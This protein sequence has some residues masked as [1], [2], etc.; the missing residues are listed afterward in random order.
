MIRIGAALNSLLGRRRVPVLLQMTNVECGAACLA[1]ILGYH[2]RKTTVVECREECGVGR[3]GASARVL[4]Q[5]ARRY[6][7]EARAFSTEPSNCRQASLPA[8]AHWG[9][10]HFIVVERWLPHGVVVVDPGL[11]RRTLTEK[12]FDAEFTGVLLTFEPGADF[13]RSKRTTV[14]AW[15][16]YLRGLLNVPGLRGVLAQVLAASLVLQLLGLV[17]PLFTQVLVD[18]VLPF[19]ITNL[20]TILGVGLLII[21]LAQLVTTYL[22]A[23][24]LL[25]LRGRLDAQTMIGFFEHLLSLPFQFF[26][27]RGSGDLLSRISSNTVIRSIMTTQTL[28]MVLDG[29]LVLVYLAILLA[30][31]PTFGLLSLLLGAAQAALLLGT[32]GRQLRMAQEYL[33]AESNSQSYL[34]EAL[35]GIATLKASGGEQRAIDRWSKLFF[36]ELNISMRRG[37]LEAGID[38]VMTGLRLLSPLL[39]LWVGAHQVLNGTVSLGTM[40]ALNALS[41]SFLSPLSS[42]ISNA[43]Q[44]QLAGAYL[45]RIADVLRTPP[46]QDFAHMPA[47]P[48]LT[49]RVEL[50]QVSFRYSSEGPWALRDVQVH[51]EPGQK[52]AIVGRSGSGKTTLAMLLLGLHPPTEGEILYDGIPLGQ[53]NYRSLRGQFG[54]VLQDSPLFSGSIRENIALNAPGITLDQIKEAARLA[55]IHDEIMQMPMTYETVVAEGGYGLSGGQCQRLT[56]ARA[57]ASQPALL[58]LDEATS[59]LDAITEEQ[60][61]RNLSGLACTR[62]VIAHRLSTVRNADLILMVDSGQIVESG[63]HD[64]LLTL[65]GPYAALVKGQLGRA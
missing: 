53:M 52:V 2:G 3:D 24:L 6:G 10:N 40:L 26:Q 65:D 35:T 1:M 12:E 55:G 61:D 20:L 51:I 11:G 38:A 41:L 21:V 14:S 27:Q 32:A 8:I 56:I 23:V 39:L 17:V 22:R 5:A 48:R 15:R 37:H 57:L 45:D 19:R 54:V 33:A 50:H 29:G 46:E 28:S 25:Y 4:M 44:L 9:F 16:E 62:I 42:L 43:E 7:M 36:K 59:H 63:M 18:H 30:W 13:D 47:A 58:L 60:V 31:D 34:V 64:H 49:G